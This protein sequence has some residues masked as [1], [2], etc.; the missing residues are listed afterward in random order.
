MKEKITTLFI[1]AILL[2]AIIPVI[3]INTTNADIENDFSQSTQSMPEQYISPQLLEKLE[4]A[5]VN[6]Q[7][8]DELVKIL[9]RHKTD[10]N[11]ELPEGVEIL[12]RFSLV[13]II[14]AS[15]PLS[16][17][18]E[19]S[20]LSGVEYVYLDLKMKI[21]SDEGLELPYPDYSEI[22]NWQNAELSDEEL[23]YNQWFG[24]Y[25][26]YLNET[27]ELIGATE[28]WSAGITGKN[29]TI[30]I[31]DTGINKY[32]PDLD[33]MD[34][35]P[36]TCDPK[37]LAEVS[38]VPY[39]SPDDLHGHGTHV[40]S[41]AAGTGA[42][43]AMGFIGTFPTTEYH[44]ATILP[45]TERGVAPGAY[46]YN[47][48]AFDQSGS[49]EWSWIIGAIEWSVTHGADIISGSFGGWPDVSADQDPVVLALKEAVEH[50]VVVVIAAGNNGFGYFTVTTPGFAPDVIT[51]G[52]TSETDHLIY[53]S[54]RG[55][56]QFG[57][58][59][60]PDIV[61]PGAGVVAAFAFYREY[62]EYMGLQT[63][64]LEI[65]GTS[66]ATPHVSGAAALLLQAFPGATP[67]TVKA[68]M[69]QGADD[70]G[71]D[72]M[73]QGAGRLNVKNAYDTMNAAPKTQWATP[74]PMGTAESNPPI[75]TTQLNLTGKSILV[76]TSLSNVWKFVNFLSL[77][78]NYGASITLGFAPY[79]NA[80]LVD[81]ITGQ[82]NYDV[83][84]I[85]D[86]YT[87]DT[88]M[89]PPETLE[90]YVQHNGTL[91][92]IGENV[93]DLEAYDEW[94]G[95]WGITWNNTAVGGFSSHMNAHIITG[96]ITELYFGNPI[97]SLIV[98]A[99]MSAE[100]V[101]WDPALPAVA[102]WEASAPATGKV[103][104]VSDDGLLSDQ[105]LYMVD[106]LQ[107]GLN[108]ISWFTDASEVEFFQDKMFFDDVESGSGSWTST[109]FWH[110]TDHRS[111][112]SSHAWYYG[113]DFVWNYDNGL[114]NSGD[115]TSP[116]IILSSGYGASLMFDCWY[117]TEQSSIYDQR[118]IYIS[119][120]SGPFVP[121]KQIYR[122]TM[123]AWHTEEIDL[124]A[125]MGHTIQIRF[126][127]DTVDD[128]AND[129][130]GWYIDDV[131]V[132]VK[133]LMP[134]Y[135]EIG[136][137]G[138]WP[139]YVLANRTAT[140]SV[141]VTN[142]GTY[143]EDVMLYMNGINVKN[144]TGLLPSTSAIVDT[145]MKLN[146]TSMCDL[147][148]V[149]MTSLS[150]WGTIVDPELDYTNNGFT[151]EIAAAPKGER[152][153]DNP[154][155]S[156]M[157]PMEIESLS[158]PLIT[159]Y[160]EDF[161]L[162]NLTV[163]VGGGALVNAQLRITG[164]VSQIADF[165]NV[166]QFTY[167]V[168]AEIFGE[169]LPDPSPAYFVPNMTSII[170]DTITIDDVSA[171]AMLFAE[172][173]VYIAE[174]T[175]IGMYTGQVELVNG[176]TTI[177]STSLNFDVQE[178]KYK[179][180]WED[181]YNDY[182]NYWADC[183]RLWGGAEWGTGVSEWWKMAA[184]AGFDVDSL[185]Q[186]L[187]FRQHRGFLVDAADPLE[188][189][190]YGGYDALCMHDVDFPFR[191]NEILVF[192][193]LYEAGKMDFAILF[194]SGGES[195][196]SFT[197]N[198]G[199]SLAGPWILDLLVTGLDKTHPIFA[200]VDNFTMFSGPVL[201]VTPYNTETSVTTGI[202]TGTDDSGLG[203]ASGFVVAVNE[204][205]ANSHYT[206]RM[207]TVG[208]SYV[209]EW[210]EYS[211]F[212]AWFYTFAF[213]GESV[214]LSSV[215]TDKFAVN[216]L[217][218]LDPQFANESPIVDYIS[219]T[220]TTS[221]LGETISV[222]AVVH[223]QEGDDFS[224]TIAVQRPDSSWDNA[225]VASVGGHWLRSFTTDLEGAY[226]V[227][228][229]AT[230]AY[231]ATTFMLG[232][233]VNAE[234]M[235]PKIVSSSISPS[236][237]AV[238]E[239]VFIAT[240]GEDPEDIIPARITISIISPVGVRQDFNYSNVAAANVV[241]DTT[242]KA[243]GIYQV[244]VTV[245]DSNGKT[246]TATVGSFEI[247]VIGFQFPVSEATFGIGIIGLVVLILILFLIYRRFPAPS[248]VP[249][250]ANST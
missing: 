2:M 167:H 96:G 214:P 110:I 74:T 153:G 146:A 140:I 242:D 36:T 230:D 75:F 191:A 39:E 170:G 149:N 151:A 51:V 124:S 3:K 70:L 8:S 98:N 129:F 219:I 232:G 26:A 43:G 223:D 10:V 171:P 185:H 62:E 112:S 202:A 235:A 57:L 249:P 67:Y 195:I 91:L 161:T 209:F 211:D 82:P 220:P 23:P 32:H 122:E 100:T 13:P 189:I 61:A 172:L 227:Y 147:S 241:F 198:Y 158:M 244:E 83:F 90:H 197:Y 173:Q 119:V 203:W 216:M 184:E 21:A 126:F 46:L 139:E 246:T 84:I 60:K 86:P 116:Q 194:D 95:I 169:M 217:R 117:E 210:L 7:A 78:E 93:W 143:T 231:D 81:T 16:M 196:S 159:M 20:K 141:N 237:V 49:G 28:M 193:Q 42:T 25:P 114:S 73:A 101:V 24:N 132:V 47:A 234:N 104:V 236:K 152:K 19:I 35:N 106:N 138:T 64:Y 87:I 222:D 5:G 181:Y 125:F 14:S 187:Y 250:Q 183:E 69:M 66:M 15:A 215:D 213:S 12:K 204:M 63:F 128:I 162:H 238:G 127:F 218:W 168:V 212:M 165:V 205:Q 156:V 55:P 136:V 58:H 228:V 190:V 11:V 38:F 40:A 137:G 4:E 17:I 192:R 224:V 85:P 22:K 68:A 115:L 102:V 200:D 199:I 177:A 240:S 208:G 109:G 65:S 107:F 56:E 176:T 71:L 206:S 18:E 180:L 30:A 92:I 54:S 52:A 88:L 77:L 133:Q 113:Q 94:T 80:T 72:S 59:A 31:I 37:V 89:L 245:E 76:D 120:D 142:F 44:N 45:G 154:L 182:V 53:F 163:F 160:P 229:V 175:P 243:E 50:G 97:A 150:I 105:F 148:G 9:I 79:T 123:G 27:T 226:M 108:V 155:L 29:V 201:T 179:V 178:P 247:T 6:H 111:Y 99:S 248:S 145:G 118:W 221:E 130:E 164:N 103:V 33:D 157:T 233:T 121:L 144:V 225:T 34:D 207:V 48:K 41:I 174:D 134:T 188:I 186:Q 166:T 131:T 135:H 239:V 1:M